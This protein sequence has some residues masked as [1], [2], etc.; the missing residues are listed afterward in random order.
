MLIIKINDKWVM[1]YHNKRWALEVV[2]GN[3][4]GSTILKGVFKMNSIKSVC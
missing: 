4:V 3:Q 1:N 2:S